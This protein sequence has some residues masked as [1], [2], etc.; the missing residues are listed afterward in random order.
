MS[1]SRRNRSR[2]FCLPVPRGHKVRPLDKKLENL[3]NYPPYRVEMV[4]CNGFQDINGTPFI[5]FVR[6]G[7][8]SQA[9]NFGYI[10]WK[11]WFRDQPGVPEHS[12]FPTTMNNSALTSTA[13]DEGDWNEQVRTYVRACTRSDNPWPVKFYGEPG[14]PPIAFGCEGVLADFEDHRPAGFYSTVPMHHEVETAPIDIAPD[15]SNLSRIV[16]PR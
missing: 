15:G 12:L 3:L 8:P 9:A 10:M 14:Y 2:Q 7:E 4:I 13:L 6:A 16:V 5:V 11:R 1:T